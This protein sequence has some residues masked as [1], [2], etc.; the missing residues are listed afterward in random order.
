M[1]AERAR[2]SHAVAWSLSVLA[3]PVLYVLTFPFV[4]SWGGLERHADGR[5]SLPSWLVVYAK[6]LGWANQ[7][8]WFRKPVDA[9]ADWVIDRFGLP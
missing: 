6:P 5:V 1:S 2:Q 9:Y 4:Q 7:Y 3:V 8:E